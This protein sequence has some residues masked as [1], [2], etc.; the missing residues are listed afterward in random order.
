MEDQEIVRFASEI[1]MN[2]HELSDN[3]IL[4][5]KIFTKTEEDKLFE[6]VM[7]SIYSFK[8]SKV[9]SQIHTIRTEMTTAIANEDESEL[10]CLMAQQ[11]TLEQIKQIISKKM[12]R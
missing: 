6:A 11:V 1:E 12:G 7:G 5:H 2:Q 10:M 9:E 3:W 8:I 4:K